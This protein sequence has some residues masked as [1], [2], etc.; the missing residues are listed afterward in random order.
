MQKYI[1]VPCEFSRGSP[2]LVSYMDNNENYDGIVM[3]SEMEPVNRAIPRGDKTPHIYVKFTLQAVY[4]RLLLR[5]SPLF[6]QRELG[7][8]CEK[9]FVKEIMYVPETKLIKQIKVAK[10]DG[11]YPI[12]FTITPS[13]INSMLIWRAS[14]KIIAKPEEFA[15]LV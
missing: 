12:E 4:D 15:T 7:G 6:V 11:L 3:Y 1:N 9:C 14:Y 2:V 13:Q 5:G 8:K 10:G